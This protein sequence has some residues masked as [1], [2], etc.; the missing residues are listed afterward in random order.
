[1]LIGDRRSLRLIDQQL[2]FLHQDIQATS[3]RNLPTFLVHQRPVSA[4]VDQAHLYQNFPLRLGA[5]CILTD[6]GGEG[7]RRLSLTRRVGFQ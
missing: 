1:M 3:C 7:R 4:P 6:I 5:E 2:F